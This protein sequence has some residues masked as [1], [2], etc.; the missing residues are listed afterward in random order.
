MPTNNVESSSPFSSQV[1]TESHLSTY[2]SQFISIQNI[3]HL[4]G[5]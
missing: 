2:C 1:P 5:N 4:L 3:D